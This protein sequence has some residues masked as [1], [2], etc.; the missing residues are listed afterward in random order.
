MNLGRRYGA[1]A[2]IHDI[3]ETYRKLFAEVKEDGPMTTAM[4]RQTPPYGPE[5]PNPLKS[6]KASPRASPRGLIAD[7]DSDQKHSDSRGYIFRLDPNLVAKEKQVVRM[8]HEYKCDRAK[9]DPLGKA[10]SRIRKQTAK[11]EGVDTA[12]RQTLARKSEMTNLMPIV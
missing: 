3:D 5:G 1:R 4:L 2:P 7:L 9:K 11:P 12:S 6:P 10:Y 8:L